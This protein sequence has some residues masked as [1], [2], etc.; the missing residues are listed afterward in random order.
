V[1]VAALAIA[2]T[3]LCWPRPDRLSWLATDWRALHGQPWRFLTAAFAH[4]GPLHLGFNVYWLWTL[5]TALEERLGHVRLLVMIIALAVTASAAEFALFAGGVGLS[6]V[7]Y[8]LLGIAW[9]LAR[10]E[11]AQAELVDRKTLQLFLGWGALCILTTVTK[12]FPVGNAAHAAGLGLGILLGLGIVRGAR[13]HWAAVAAMAAVGLAATVVRPHINLD[14][15]RSA[16]ELAYAGQQRS[17]AGQLDEAAKLFEEALRYKA[18]AAIWANLGY[19]Q[20][21]LQRASEARR[22][23]RLACDSQYGGGCVNLAI[24]LEGGLGGPAD[25]AAA[26]DLHRRGCDA[27]EPY[28][29]AN[30]ARFVE[31]E[32][33]LAGALAL[34]AR[35]CRGAVEPACQ[36]LTAIRARMAGKH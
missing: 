25:R 28:G 33:D 7:A 20:E 24:M 8:G 26:R 9:M 22:S 35:G 21:G 17:Q 3:V 5:G 18:S 2:A 34:Y 11:P 1:A 6:G 29:C 27:G 32:G 12:V 4:L 16:Q 15:E 30:L 36:A 19:V 31:A 23:Y 13:W 14:R 10:Y